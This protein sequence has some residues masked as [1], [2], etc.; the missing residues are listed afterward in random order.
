MLKQRKNLEIV[1]AGVDEQGIFTGYASIFGVVDEEDDIMEP[2]AF[3]DTLATGMASGGV[4]IFGQ[5]EDEEPP[6][7]KSLELKEDAKGLY[8]KGLISATP[9]GLTYRQL[10]KDR[11]LTKMSIGYIILEYEIDKNGIRHIKKVELLEISVVN[12]PANT[13]ANIESYKGGKQA[14][15]VKKSTN[16]EDNKSKKNDTPDGETEVTLSME[17]LAKIVEDASELGAAKALKQYN[18]DEDDEDKND[19][20][21]GEG[22][23]DDPDDEGKSDD[24]DGEGKNDDPEGEGKGKKGRKLARSTKSYG[25]PRQAAQRKY[26]DIYMS[27]GAKV[28][29]KGTGL[30]KG[31]A[32]ARYQKA[33]IRAGGDPD[34][35]SN[36]AKKS[37]GDD[38]MAREIKALGQN[39]TM[40]SDGGYLVPED[41][42]AEVIELLYDRAVLLKLGATVIPMER[43][44][45]N[46][47]KMIKGNT[48]SYVGE[49]RK[50]KQ[51]QAEFGNIKLSSKKLMTKIPISNDLIRSNAYQ[52]DSI[53]L[54]DA[55]T[56]MALAMDRA[57]FLGKGTDFEPL[58]L[59]EMKDVETINLSS[60]P[61]TTTSGTMLGK[62]IQKNVDTSNIAW[63]FNGYAW[64]EFYNVVDP[65]SGLFVYRQQMDEGKLNGQPYE[66]ANQLP[67]GTDGHK[68]TKIVLGNWSEFLIGRQG[69]MES[70]IFDQGTISLD[71]GTMISAVDND[72]VILRCLDLHDFGVRHPE[73]FVIGNIY[74]A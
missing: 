59:F 32:W 44:S 43:G 7:G 9:E 74:T 63:A 54:N 1:D 21:D 15:K 16:P 73:S 27:T 23:N 6:I 35:A 28:E 31:I 11:V 10:I 4:M 72:V 37:F 34:R 48:A 14:V 52:A 3:A 55:V 40:P 51:S 38:R 67:L 56:Q 47:P 36:I 25:S 22:K 70:M 24:P 64:T 62:L 57:G 69:Q 18:G 50:A 61:N 68:S 66:V 45:I 19:D 46:L 65:T 8:V 26:S 20:P 53:I 17:E 71:D 39:M 42:A 5:H 41:Y 49:M 33:M 58:G 60:L 13:G 30:P 29:R 12:Y 2:G